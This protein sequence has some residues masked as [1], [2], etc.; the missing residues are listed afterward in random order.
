MDGIFGVGI[1]E[2]LIIGLALFIIGGP[3]NT[4]KWARDLGRMVRQV[5]QAWADMMVEVE[6]DLGPEGKE[7]MDATRELNQTARSLRSSTSPTSRLMRD[8]TRLLDDTLDEIDP[9]AGK[10][11]AET[12]NSPA[13]GKYRAWLPPDKDQ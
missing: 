3:E 6:R 7:L 9:A 13:N 2:M 12:T 8:A 10:K 5:R 4:A 1:A 11:A